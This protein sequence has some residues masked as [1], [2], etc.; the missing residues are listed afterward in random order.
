MK[1]VTQKLTLYK[2]GYGSEMV[3]ESK[4][5]PPVDWVRISKPLTVIFELLSDVEVV[6]A[7][8]LQINKEIE[9]IKDE[10]LLKINKLETKRQEL[11][12]LTEEK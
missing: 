4:F 1:N 3:W 6:Q 5:P 9:V 12:A 7:E 11:L 8:V 10:A 2:T